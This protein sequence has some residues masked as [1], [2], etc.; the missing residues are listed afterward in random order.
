MC[1]SSCSLCSTCF[2]LFILYIIMENCSPAWG[3]KNKEK[4][5]YMAH[6][7]CEP[8]PGDGKVVFRQ[9]F[10]GRHQHDI[11][12][13]GTQKMMIWRTTFETSS[14]I[15]MICKHRGITSLCRRKVMTSTSTWST[16]MKA[17]K[18]HSHLQHLYLVKATNGSWTRI[19]HC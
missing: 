3:E 13:M 2:G 12:W 19:Y 6:G 16:C 18:L 4:S 10:W 15:S 17:K 5:I 14:P 11:A 7:H 1:K 9:N 8:M